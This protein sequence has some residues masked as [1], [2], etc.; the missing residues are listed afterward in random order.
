M[1]EGR[2]REQL[3]YLVSISEAQQSRSRNANRVSWTDL[4]PYF[5]TTNNI[6]SALIY[7]SQELQGLGLNC[8]LVSD[9]GNSVN[10]IALINGCW[11]VLQLYQEQVK[12]F[13][14]HQDQRKR[15]HADLTH[16]Q[17]SVRELRGSVEEKERLVIDAQE[18]ERQI[19][20][21]NRAITSKLKS[22]KEEVKKLGSILQQRESQHQH[23]LRK[24]ETEN[25]RLRE[26][27]TRLVSGDRSIDSRPPGISISNSL[28]RSD[29]ARGK[30]KTE[31]MGAKHEEIMHMKI[32]HRY[33]VWVGQ[34]NEE[35]EQLKNCLA[36]LSSQITKFAAK[37]GKNEYGISE[38]DMNT[39]MNSSMYSAD[40]LDEPIFNLDAA[41]I[42]DQV[43]TVL[44]DHLNTIANAFEEKSNKLEIGI[45]LHQQQQKELDDL[46]IQV[47]QL[48]DQLTYQRTNTDNDEKDKENANET[49]L[50]FL[51]EGG[52]V[53]ERAQLDRER[54]KVENEQRTLEKERKTFADATIRLN[55]ERAAFEAEKV[56]LL[57]RQ[58]LNELP[59]TLNNKDSDISSVLQSDETLSLSFHEN[60]IGSISDVFGDSPSRIVVMP[61]ITPPRPS[62][63]VHRVAQPIILGTT[64]LPRQQR[65]SGSG[66]SSRASSGNRMKSAPTSRCTSVTRE[67]PTRDYGRISQDSSR[68]STIDR[69]KRRA[70]NTQNA[71][72]A[73]AK[74]LYREGEKVYPKSQPSSPPP[75]YMENLF[76]NMNDDA[77][78]NF[79]IGGL[80]RERGVGAAKESFEISGKQS[81][82]GVP[83]GSAMKIPRGSA[84]GSSASSANDRESPVGDQ[85]REYLLSMGIDPVAAC[86]A[87]RLVRNY[88][89]EDSTPEKF[90][91]RNP[92]YGPCDYDD[93]NIQMD[94]LGPG[95]SEFDQG[96]DA[97]STRLSTLESDLMDLLTQIGPDED[98]KQLDHGGKSHQTINQFIGENTT[99]V[100]LG[101]NAPGRHSVDT[102]VRLGLPKN[103]KA[104]TVTGS[105]YTSLPGS[106]S[107]SRRNSQELSAA[108]EFFKKMHKHLLKKSSQNQ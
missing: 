51:T 104:H 43:Q 70:Q 102:P 34:L 86:A 33:E 83:R 75:T 49:E 59:D 4:P 45:E 12:D 76:S 44:Q 103:Q 19:V 1:S 66:M 72:E 15:E 82:L 9:G 13:S 53:E 5:C 28:L 55:R 64:R 29:K 11:E 8:R 46:R 54:K 32:L 50:T 92:R 40:S 98:E 27:L 100:Y 91:I 65:E 6:Q 37:Y 22:E 35:N 105:R 97:N 23:E 62:A 95:K 74:S 93:D 36:Q 31:A 58:F 106:L 81:F 56:E 108:E 89:G 18:K 85:Y 61:T 60:S 57:R 67:E 94:D 21:L 78:D 71:R 68:R 99:N 17:S 42:R 41:S 30:W 24:K 80:V 52:C 79:K 7:L 73:R 48:K 96:V 69:I 88:P 87:R 20:S 2:H 38:G 16:L 39:S 101:Q 3:T 47:A 14:S 26:R 77:S 63:N 10:L 84:A 90:S 107:S 25:N